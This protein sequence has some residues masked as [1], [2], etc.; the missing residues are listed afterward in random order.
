MFALFLAVMLVVSVAG[1]AL[2]QC[3]GNCGD[4]ACPE[5]LPK[6]DTIKV[7][8][9][10][11]P[12]TGLLI[13]EECLTLCTYIGCESSFGDLTMPSGNNTGTFNYKAIATGANVRKIVGKLLQSMETDVSL[14]L[15]L[16]APGAFGA[17]AGEKALT[18]VN[19]DFVTG[20]SKMCVQDGTGTLRLAAGMNAEAI[21]NKCVDVQLTIMD[22]AS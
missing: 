21:N 20:L 8:Y 7:C 16:A 1:G 2:A 3:G 11:V 17:S 4:P 12:L 15:N 5:Y 14:H 10:V 6:N 9:S 19:Q 18:M 13:T 22:Q